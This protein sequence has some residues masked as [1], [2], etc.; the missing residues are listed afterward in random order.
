MLDKT[1]IPHLIEDKFYALWES[2]G[3]FR[4]SQSP[5][6]TPYVIMMPPPNVTGSLHMGHALTYSLQD[7]LIRYHRMKGQD[8]LW[9]PGMD[10]AGI[11][12]QAVVE[13]QM[14]AE[15][16][17]RQDLGR[18]KFLERVW[19]WKS[20][21]GGTIL[22]QQRQLGLSADW[23][24][25]RFTLDDGLSD[26]VRTIF[27]CLFKD[28]IIYRAKRLVNWDPKLQTAVSD[29]EVKSIETK[30]KLY[31]L[32]YQ[33]E[34]SDDF[35][36]VAT[37]RPE[38][39]FGDTAVAVHPKDERYHAFLGKRVIVPL[40]G[41]S[42]PVIVD[43]YCDPT[44]GSGAVKI[45]PAHDFN[46]F[47]V[48]QRHQLEMIAIFDK[49]AHLNE[50]VA[51]PFQGLERF[52][53][54][55]AVVKALEQLNLIDKIDDI[56]HTLPY[57]ERS[58]EILE[59]Y[60]TD[61]WFVDAKTLAQPALAAVQQ[62]RTQIVPQQFEATYHRWL[63]NIQP[64]CI[65][66]QLWWGHRIPAWYGPDGH[67]FVALDV[68]EAQTQALQHY[69]HAV[70]LIQDEDV[71][72]T[73][74]SSAL[75]PFSTL[76]WPEQTAELE[77]YYPTSVLVTGVD[78]LFFWVARMMMMGLYVMKD[79]PF[80]TVYL[81]A[82]VRDQHGQKMSKS[83]GNVV[84][85]LTLMSTYGADALRFSMAALAAPAR[86]VK[87]STPV[88]E[89]YRNFATKLWNATRFCLQNGA[90]YQEDFDPQTCTLSVN[91]WMISEVI[92]LAHYL[93]TELAAYC[94]NTAASALYQ[95]IWGQFC[96][97]YLE[98]I[99]PILSGDDPKAQ[100][101][102]RA[103]AAWCVA[104]LSHLLHPFMPFITEE[105]WQHIAPT[106]SALL[107]MSPWPC[108]HQSLAAWTQEPSRQDIAW[109]ID[110]ITTVRRLK[111]SFNLSPS[112]K[113]TLGWIQGSS[114]TGQRLM[115]Y[116]ALLE[117]LGRLDTIEENQTVPQGAVQFKVDET[118]F[119]LPLGDLID[120]D[121]ERTRLQKKLAE[122][123]QTLQDLE[124]K[125]G[126]QEFITK[127]PEEIVDKIQRRQQEARHA[128]LH[129]EQALKSL[130]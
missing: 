47:E 72:D 58:N 84:N 129:L 48:G 18:D 105:I 55:D 19:Q 86:D 9:Q 126:N 85:P 29:L 59:P 91:R 67:I 14:D 116:H 37:T 33:I 120:S 36:I 42:I 28:N 98:F 8:V 57:G 118:V 94:F 99:K 32:K 125:L 61:Q 50:N 79:V 87:F 46:D 64:W 101:E 130:Y 45:T 92:I 128:Q 78:I 27:V 12:T 82:L 6:K 62:K 76:G 83:K 96:D 102:T 74:F 71:L 41:R 69:G 15:G 24:R 20:E 107:M 110:I 13:R 103:C 73:W 106:P 23:T 5:D 108:Q 81:H 112:L 65:S 113:L 68:H 43:E 56:V 11:A 90:V 16:L 17:K 35:I 10:H 109:V 7:I 95:T 97:W 39:L 114:Q 122:T 21:S 25:S 75:W 44:K 93:D 117:R 127:A 66:R 119:Y 40:Q 52:K 115:Q 53:A 104:N 38:T 31:Y 54:R 124:K 34:H 77:R 49:H 51:A 3:C 88:V 80:K 63:E 89:G 60:L 26:A 4:T 100:Q 1:F 70:D 2:T 123:Q 22:S 30:G 121:Q 111:T